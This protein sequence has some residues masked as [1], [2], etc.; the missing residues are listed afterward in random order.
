[1]A[2]R[3]ELKYEDAPFGVLFLLHNH[4]RGKEERPLKWTTESG[5]K[6]KKRD[7]ANKTINTSEI[8]RAPI[9]KDISL[10]GKCAEQIERVQQK[11]SIF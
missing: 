1:M 2:D 3:A 7:T 10:P 8:I 6:L 4:T 11:L 5:G 9:R